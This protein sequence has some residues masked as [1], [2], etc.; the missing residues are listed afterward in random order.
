MD[1]AKVP[2][3]IAGTPALVH[4]H[5]SRVDSAAEIQRQ[6]ASAV[7][8][9]P[10]IR[11]FEAEAGIKLGDI[12][13]KQAKI[14]EKKQ[15]DLTAIPAAARDLQRTVKPK[16]T[17]GKKD[18]SGEVDINVPAAG[19]NSGAPGSTST[20]VD[21]GPFESHF[22]GYSRFRGKIPAPA[23]LDKAKAKAG[24]LNADPRI[25]ATGPIVLFEDREH[26]PDGAIF[27]YKSPGRFAF[28]VILRCLSEK[29]APYL[30]PL[31]QFRRLKLAPMPT[32]SKKGKAALASLL[33]PDSDDD[34]GTADADDREL[35]KGATSAASVAAADDGDVEMGDF[36]ASDVDI[37]Y[38]STD[39]DPGSDDDTNPCC[40]P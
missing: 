22:P 13:E 28:L 33:D 2:F 34:A 26:R 29:D 39:S 1:M 16:Y 10:N 23:E 9:G 19:L 38:I 3:A 35:S 7:V 25:R 24:E 36:G 30:V 27:T 14:E 12:E 5:D 18:A 37:A 17:R 32:K 4:N 11:Q 6:L 20:V 31:A 21:F 8:L 40:K 15:A